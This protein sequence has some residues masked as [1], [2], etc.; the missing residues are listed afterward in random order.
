M[1]FIPDHVEDLYQTPSDIPAGKRTCHET[2]TLAQ[3]SANFFCQKC[4]VVNISDVVGSAVCLRTT[5]LLSL[6]HESNTDRTSVDD[7]DCVLIKFYSQK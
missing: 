7:W 3:A 1:G 6:E 5:L 2:E 4:Q